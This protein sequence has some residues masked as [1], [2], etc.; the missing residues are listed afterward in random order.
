MLA[1]IQFVSHENWKTP[2][3]QNVWKSADR[4]WA[5]DLHRAVRCAIEPTARG[6]GSMFWRPRWGRW[7][8][9]ARIRYHSGVK[10]WCRTSCSSTHGGTELNMRLTLKTATGRRDCG[11]CARCRG[12]GA[13]QAAKFMLFTIWKCIPIQS[14]RSRMVLRQ[15]CSRSNKRLG[16]GVPGRTERDNSWETD[17]QRR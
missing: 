3:P 11:R 6:R 8:H 1:Q 5:V 7:C 17:Y 14:L 16:L 15:S 2:L 12:R 10:P 4:P 13:A 9:Q